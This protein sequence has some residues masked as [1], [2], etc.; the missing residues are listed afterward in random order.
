MK[1]AFLCRRFRIAKH[2][3]FR[4]AIG[5]KMTT[6]YLLI[7]RLFGKPRVPRRLHALRHKLSNY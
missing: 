5:A 4:S 2:G 1:M 3:N 6:L 7:F